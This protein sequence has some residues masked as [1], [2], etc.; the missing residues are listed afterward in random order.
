MKR[1]MTVRKARGFTLIELVIAIAVIALL[2]VVAYPSYRQHLIRAS[3][4]AAKS[5][6]VDFAALQEKIYLN[7]DAYASSVTGAY[8]G[9]AAGGLGRT[10]G[11]TNDGKYSMSLVTAAQSFTM[12]ATPVT[13]SLQVGDGNLAI[14]SD[15][16][17]TWG[18]KIW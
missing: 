12:T 6:L 15:G 9:N 14:S 18:S 10:S 1:A 16:T 17:R 2:T 4:E 3:R 8:T 7:S 5:E 11:K 13:G